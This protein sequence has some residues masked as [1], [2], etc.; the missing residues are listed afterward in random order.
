MLPGWT[1]IVQFSL[2]HEL[3]FGVPHQALKVPVSK[4]YSAR[5]SSQ[6]AGWPNDGVT[7]HTTRNKRP[8]NPRILIMGVLPF[9]DYRRSRSTVMLGVST[10]CT[11]RELAGI[12]AWYMPGARSGMVTER[13]SPARCPCSFA[14]PMRSMVG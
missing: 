7:E 1:V 2:P 11:Q 5:Q 8:M 3:L 12:Q 6:A 9:D 13:P 4:L 14:H 10:C